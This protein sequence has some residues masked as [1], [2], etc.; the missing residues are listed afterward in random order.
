MRGGGFVYAVVL[1]LWFGLSAAARAQQNPPDEAVIADRLGLTA[2]KLH[3]LEPIMPRAV[4]HLRLPIGG[5][6]YDITL[7]PHS[8]RSDRF[9]VLLCRGDGDLVPVELPA[10]TTYRGHIAQAPDALVA[11]TIEGGQLHAMILMDGNRRQGEPA[12]FV[13]PLGRSIEDASA[14][15]HIIFS[16]AHAP[17]DHHQCGGGL[18][19]FLPPPAP[20]APGGPEGPDNT[21]ICEIAIDADF[22]FYQQN[23]S[24]ISATTSDVSTIINNISL[25]YESQTN[26][27]FQ[28]TDVIV[29]TTNFPY[30]S[31]VTSSNLLNQF[32]NHWNANH[33]SVQRDIAHLFTGITT[34]DSN[35]IGLAWVSVVCNQSLAYGYSRSRYSTNMSRRTG[36]TAHEVGHNF[37]AEHCNESG[38]SCS[39]CAIM[40]SSIGGCGGNSTSLA[41]SAGPIQNYAA[42]LPCLNTG[43]ASPSIATQP[44]SR[45][46]DEGAS[47]QFSIS[48]SGSSPL[49][50]QWRRNGQNLA[51]GNGTS[52]AT[53]PTLT[54]NPVAT[55]HAGNYTCVVTGPCGSATSEIATLTVNAC[56]TPAITVHPQPREASLGGIA[57]FSITASGAG[58]LT[59][60]WKRDGQNLDNGNG[61]AGA[62]TASLTI[63]P[64]AASH[65]GLYACTVSNA[66]GPVTSNSALLTITQCQAPAITTQ[67]VSRGVILGQSV[68]F[69]VA[70]EGEAPL[71][72][73]WRRNNNPLSN[74]ASIS[75]AAEPTLLID[76]VSIADAGE[77]T[78]IIINACGQTASSPATL[79]IFSPPTIISQPTPVEVCAGEAVII[80]AGISGSE[81][82]QYQWRR[83]STSLQPAPHRSGIN[84]PVL[85]INP[86]QESDSGVYTLHISNMAGSI[87][88]QAAN[89]TVQ[90][91]AAISSQPQPLSLPAGQRATFT[92]ETQGLPVTAYRWRRNGQDLADSG[93]VFGSASR[94]LTINPTQPADAG[95]YSVRIEHAC[96]QTIS[97]SATLTIT[98]AIPSTIAWWRFEEG[99]SGD[100][101]TGKMRKNASAPSQVNS[102]ALDAIL[103]RGEPRY[104]H[105]TPGADLEGVGANNLALA[106]HGEDSLRV[107][108]NHMLNFGPVASPT[109][110]FTIEMFAKIE[111]VAS[112]ADI[113]PLLHKSARFGEMQVGY[114]TWV[115]AGASSPGYAGRLSSAFS[116][117][118]G[119]LDHLIAPRIDD[120]RWR[121]V[122]WRRYF[123]GQTTRTD[124][125][126][127]YQ[128]EASAVGEAHGDL[129]NPADLLI[130][131]SESG[132]EYLTGALDEIRI[133]SRP[134]H[135]WEF[136]RVAQASTCYANCDN[137]STQPSLTAADFTCFINQFTL[138][139]SLPHEQQVE[140][141]ANCDGSTRAPVL[142]IDD[143]V[144]FMERFAAGCN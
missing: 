33:A 54:I 74:T 79:A 123:D 115:W 66:C 55:F 87:I 125:W 141:Y 59:Y 19:S 76:P 13:Q 10:E 83:N 84:S 18:R 127:D 39:P 57:S 58:P 25:T 46:V 30:T 41:C 15:T 108:A 32:R 27:I 116:D 75:G 44:V 51:S 114:Q 43:C 67:P 2:W 134:L 105:D 70:A 88:T 60:Q 142:T 7:T 5:R 96:G 71:T 16:S 82:L 110:E 81:P 24:S 72:Y 144:C 17:A 11:A 140:H 109:G 64:V 68:S 61:I 50:Y 106:F 65:A 52:G 63:D 103:H 23:G 20:P 78:C 35:I 22:A 117:A 14:S 92:V 132:S 121:H 120:G 131:R 73:Q 48:A 97:E 45:S 85:T 21:R 139:Q 124:L 86:A 138:A 118:G 101:A 62:N 53:S 29:R 93:A 128:L 107:A 130:G 102:P 42:T 40:C 91:G 111:P 143:F 9:Q 135:V 95:E 80:G 34:S 12:W 94:T 77:Y 6:E 112:G 37:S 137:S 8:V 99:R 89:I 126:I 31:G 4:V 38:S 69:S 56:E 129:A 136:L 113:Y 133:S 36:L 98:T 100:G 90:P 49:A 3:D 26:I 119:Q 28:I 122:A 47:V 104:I 1:C